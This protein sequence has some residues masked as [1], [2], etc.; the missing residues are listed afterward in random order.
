[1]SSSS[2]YG[3]I[4]AHGE[5]G[6]QATISFKRETEEPS[7]FARFKNVAPIV[8]AV[9]VVGGLFISEKTGLTNVVLHSAFSSSFRAHAS[10]SIDFSFQRS[11]YDI[12]PY[13]LSESNQILQ[14]KFLEKYNGVIEPHALNQLAILTSDSSVNSYKYSLCSTSSTSTCYSGE[15]FPEDVDSS[16]GVTVP[17]DS[18]DEFNVEVT[19]YDSNGVVLTYTE[20]SAVCM[21]VR[22]E[23]QSLTQEDLKSTMDTMY[24]LWTTPE[25]EG[26]QL[27]G[28]NYHDADYF[29]A[30]HDFNAAQ[31]DADHIHE[32]LGFVPQHIKL[33]N[34]F[35][36]SL[37][38]VNPAVSLP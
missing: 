38:A 33:S 2:G 19:A 4:E 14:Y 12:L 30:A 22:R 23:I 16:T 9:G 18:F 34:W 11:G 10:N 6:F 7:Y 28:E 36:S 35:E 29:T 1:M 17:C 32:G 8:I 3:S 25:E 15:Y 13:F 27:Y 20:G 24:T 21:Y 5:D 26:Q 31:P 37:Q